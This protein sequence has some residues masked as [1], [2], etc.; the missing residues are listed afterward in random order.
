M[1]LIIINTSTRRKFVICYWQHP[2]TCRR[3]LYWIISQFSR[4]SK[5]THLCILQWPNLSMPKEASD[6][7]ICCFL[8]L[9]TLLRLHHPDCH[10]KAW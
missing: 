6:C 1:F 9:L 7:R 8:L 10:S 2:F 3:L 4:T 5:L